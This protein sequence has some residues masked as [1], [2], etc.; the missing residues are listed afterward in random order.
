VMFGKATKLISMLGNLDFDFC[1][2][3]VDECR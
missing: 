2:G 1:P 3:E